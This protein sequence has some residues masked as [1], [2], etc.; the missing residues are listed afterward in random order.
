MK[1]S[2]D[3]RRVGESA[4]PHIMKPDTKQR[5]KLFEIARARVADVTPQWRIDYAAFERII[6]AANE[7]CDSYIQAY[8]NANIVRLAADGFERHDETS[9]FYPHAGVKAVLDV[10]AD[11]E[12]LTISTKAFEAHTL[13][14]NEMGY[15]QRH[16]S[17]SIDIADIADLSIVARDDG[18]VGVT[19][20]FTADV[21]DYLK[22]AIETW[23]D[24]G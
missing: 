19:L 4:E 7:K 8:E 17:D 18:T 20:N 2:A 5:I 14:D 3:S 1:L 16:M 9:D 22:D 12:R 23:N 6:D 15:L 11:T 10:L 24:L 21:I 13:S